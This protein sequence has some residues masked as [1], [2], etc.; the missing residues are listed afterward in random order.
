MAERASSS[1]ARARAEDVPLT[2][3]LFRLYL[4]E[5]GRVELL[6]PD[7]EVDLAKRIRAGVEAQAILDDR[8]DELERAERVRLRGIV[9][10]GRRSH[11]RMV[12]TNLRLVVSVARRYRAPG[13]GFP[14]LVQEGNLGLLRAVDRF[15]PTKGYRFSTYA[16]WWIRQ[17]IGRGVT[18]Q[19]RTIRLPSHLVEL[20]GRARRA[21]RELLQQLGRDPTPEE[22]AARVEVPVE[23]LEELRRQAQAPSSLDAP[24]GKCPSTIGY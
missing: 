17:T 2:E 23:R 12:E 18:Q 14:D 3:D 1:T 9:R 19:S 5:I 13:I 20:L 4:D 24:V 16:T 10:D 15:D 7:E 21:E 22:V 6:R 11:D 8:G